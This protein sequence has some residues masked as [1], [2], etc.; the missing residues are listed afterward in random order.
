VL[1]EWRAELG[2]DNDVCTTTRRL[3]VAPVI[4][5]RGGVACGIVRAMP[6]Q[7]GGASHWSG[8]STDDQLDTTTKMHGTALPK[9]LVIR[10]SAGH[11][12]LPKC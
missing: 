5:E 1:L 2:L 8:G 6:W 3:D 11:H 4:G 12:F 7:D 9:T 10:R